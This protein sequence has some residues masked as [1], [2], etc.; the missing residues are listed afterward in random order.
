M[1]AGRVCRFAMNNSNFNFNFFLTPA[2]A[3]ARL[4]ITNEDIRV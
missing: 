4:A 2:R 1:A 3:G